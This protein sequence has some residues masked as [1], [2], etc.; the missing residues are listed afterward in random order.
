MGINKAFPS[1]SSEAHLR[2]C[3]ITNKNYIENFISTIGL[4]DSVYTTEGIGSEDPE[5]YLDK[6]VL[7]YLASMI[8]HVQ[9]NN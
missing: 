6:L 4:C 7:N 5:K 1:Q 9:N 8:Q 2:Y 3:G